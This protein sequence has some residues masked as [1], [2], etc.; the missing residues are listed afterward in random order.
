VIDHGT[1]E[2]HG[3]RLAL[4]NGSNNPALAANLA[5]VL[6][7]HDLIDARQHAAAE[8]FHK[9][10][11]RAFGVSLAVRGDGPGAS[12]GQAAVNERRYNA[13]AALLTEVQHMALVDVALDLWP[14]RLKR[15]LLGEPL[16]TEDQAERQDLLDGLNALTIG[17]PRRQQSPPA[18]APC[19]CVS[20]PP[21][22]EEG[23]GRA[24]G[25]P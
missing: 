10:R 5:G 14:G 4:V 19:R 17:A 9:A 25:R 22:P 2:L 16:A 1:P 13:L 24:G 7:A 3:K 8:R 23:S 21:R 11:A 18:G 6:L 15:Q 12:E 20:A